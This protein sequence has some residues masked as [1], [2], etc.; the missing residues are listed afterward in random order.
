M[1][2]KEGEEEMAENSSSH[3]FAYSSMELIRS[4]LWGAAINVLPS[5]GVPRGM[6]K[7]GCKDGSGRLH[8]KDKFFHQHEASSG[9]ATTKP[10]LANFGRPQNFAVGG[11]TSDDFFCATA[12]LPGTAQTYWGAGGEKRGEAYLA[13]Y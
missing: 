10:V 8:L 1:S 3:N 5:G 6:T 7:A 4:I 13:G 12:S 9:I 11:K 2:N